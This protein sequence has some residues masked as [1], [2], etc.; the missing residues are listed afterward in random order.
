MIFSFALFNSIFVFCLKFVD[1]I[2][3]GNYS[4]RLSHSCD[5]NCGTVTTIV[6]GQYVIG[7][8]A[9]KDISYGEELTFDYCSVTEEMSEFKKAFCLCGTKKCRGKY[10]GLVKTKES[11]TFLEQSHG[12][13]E[14]NNILL[15]ACRE[16]VNNKD[17]EILESFH[18]K[19][20]IME[21]M[22]EWM[23]K[24]MA[25]TLE[26]IE[27]ET[28]FTR[29]SLNEGIPKDLPFEEE[30]KCREMNEV[31]ANNNKESRFQNLVITCDKV[32]YFLKKTGK[33]EPPFTVISEEEVFK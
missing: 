10:L 5:P 3:K 32:K 16:P 13:L 2:Q 11:N 18:L 31:S 4:S 7:M 22:P 29:N 9:M 1:P 14:R 26:F 15:R 28:E 25:L 33:F 27:K 19:E 30:K 12:F 6:N 21:N 17:N 8:Y 23:K 24:W 20:R